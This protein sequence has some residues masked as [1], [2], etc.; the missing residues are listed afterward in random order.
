MNVGGAESGPSSTVPAIGEREGT[1]RPEFSRWVGGAPEARGVRV[2]PGPFL[3]TPSRTHLEPRAGKRSATNP[4][5]SCA[6]VAGRVARNPARVAVLMIR[7]GRAIQPASGV[8]ALRPGRCV[9]GEVVSGPR[10]GECHPWCGVLPIWRAGGRAT[11]QMAVPL[12]YEDSSVRPPPLAPRLLAPAC[13]PRPRRRRTVRPGRRSGDFR[14][15]TGTPGDNGQPRLSWRRLREPD[16]RHQRY[17]SSA[18][19]SREPRERTGGHSADYPA[20]TPDRRRYER[21][22]PLGCTRTVPGLH[23]ARR[24][25]VWARVHGSPRGCACR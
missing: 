7:F 21:P 22:R 15:R 2:H 13:A 16:P 25:T 23:V 14:R 20:C 10:L 11:S 12:C 18:R 6:G 3:G 24:I 1:A 8:R 5:R 9:T 19:P 4:A 17:V